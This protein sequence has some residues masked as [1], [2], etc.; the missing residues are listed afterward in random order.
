MMLTTS[1]GPKRQGA[2]APWAT[3]AVTEALVS[4]M[5]RDRDI[6]VRFAAAYA[7]G[8]LD[9]ERKI[10]PLI[11][12]LDDRNEEPKV[13]A[14]AAETLGNSLDLRALEPLIDALS[15]PAVEVRFWA[16]FAVGELG[17]EAAL[18]ELRRLAETDEAV[19]PGW[20]S[21]QDEAKASIELIEGEPGPEDDDRGTEGGAA[22]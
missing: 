7:L 3:S 12:T 2:W 11:A 20:W 18:P 22:V 19:L 14:I 21:V 8:L 5:Q 15:D 16:A 17:A 10:E 13:R 1:C 4:A 9:D 6:D